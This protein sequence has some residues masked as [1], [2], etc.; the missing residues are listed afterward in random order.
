MDAAACTRGPKQGRRGG[1]CGELDERTS[2][3]QLY[4]P[5]GTVRL[6]GTIMKDSSEETMDAH[7]VLIESTHT[8]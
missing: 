2:G 8:M 7:I 3:V 6:Y 5:R 1:G 4:V